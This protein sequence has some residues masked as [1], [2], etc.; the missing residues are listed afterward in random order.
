MR[1]I[2]SN[3]RLQKCGR[4]IPSFSFRFDDDRKVEVDKDIHNKFKVNSERVICTAKIINK[5]SVRAADV[6][7]LQ[8]N[9][10]R[11]F[12]YSYKCFTKI[13]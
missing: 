12:I 13:K 5:T 9:V 2:L 7:S 4:V 6:V 10:H 11:D 3:D 1:P 8:L